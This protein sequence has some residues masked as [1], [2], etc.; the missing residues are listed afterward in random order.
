MIEPGDT[1]LE[2]LLSG[3][4]EGVLVESMTGNAGNVFSGDFS[5]SV[6]IAFKIERGALVGRIKNAAVAGNVFA[7][8]SELGGLSSEAEWV[9]GRV[10]TPYILMRALQV[11]AKS[12]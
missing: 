5:G 1:P 7:D 12:G 3:I 8:M 4:E 2:Q 6:D 9:G 11:S 10:H